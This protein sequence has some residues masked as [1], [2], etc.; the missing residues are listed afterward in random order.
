MGDL[1][2]RTV[3]VTDDENLVSVRGDGERSE[4]CVADTHGR[5]GLEGRHRPDE[6]GK[7]GRA[8]RR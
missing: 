4:G 5:R 7:T 1:A 2:Q 3:L 8:T 6:H